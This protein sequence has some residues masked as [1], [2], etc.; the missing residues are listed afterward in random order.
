M[1]DRQFKAIRIFTE[2]EKRVED[3]TETLNTQIRN[4]IAVIKSTTNQKKHN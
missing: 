1:S 3:M 4:N 2:L